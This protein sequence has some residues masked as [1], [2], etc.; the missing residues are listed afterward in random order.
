MGVER[1]FVAMTPERLA[2]LIMGA[3]R[4]VVY[5]APSLSL[6]VA[7][8]LIN[9]HGSLGEEAVVIVIDA[10]EAVLRLGYG[11]A[12]ALGLLREKKVTIRHAEG[13]RI[14]F[15]VADDE[16]FI[17]VLPPLLVEES[18]SA[19]DRP[20]AVR[21]SRGQVEQ[22]ADAV[23][24]PPSSTSSPLLAPTM[25]AVRQPEI[26][27]SVVSPAQIEKIEE[28]IKMNP[29]ENFD[30]TRVVNVFSTYFQFFELEVAGTHIERRTVRLPKEL[31]GSIRDQATRDRITAAFRMLSKES[32]SGEAIHR[33]ASEIRKRFIRH[34][35]VYGGV[36][37]KSNRAT[38]DAE[39]AK[40]K[41]S[42]ETHSKAVLAR[43][44]RDVRKS[45]S[46]LVQAFWRDVARNPWNWPTKALTN[47]R[48][49]RLKITYATSSP[50][51]FH[52]HRT[53]SPIC[54]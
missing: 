19:D 15:V 11:V 42:V 1:I 38:L 51:L 20:N 36:I 35:P 53:S 9:V 10:D 50:R 43:L 6:S 46:G 44:D 3:R 37:L 27:R 16:G 8:A 41:L 29:V 18:S 40:L 21:A 4:R 7:S 30:L 49:R 5:A 13:L 14:S 31:L 23:P 48:P 17:F 26:G 22:L 39:V 34:H 54:A 24:R 47:R 52:E 28:A 2:K 25:P 33:Q 32:R 12:D 45:I